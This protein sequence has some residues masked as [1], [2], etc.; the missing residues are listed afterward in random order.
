[1][2]EIFIYDDSRKP[3]AIKLHST[4][5]KSIDEESNSIR[6]QV[7]DDAPNRYNEKVDQATLDSRKFL[8]E[9]NRYLGSPK[10]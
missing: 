6:F 2:T 10:W 7:S 9:P 3:E 5:I 4:E 1:M 8:E